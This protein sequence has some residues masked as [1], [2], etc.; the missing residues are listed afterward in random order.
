MIR[1]TPASF[2]AEASSYRPGLHQHT[3]DVR[4]WNYTGDRMVATP[5]NPGNAPRARLTSS[6]RRRMILE[7][8]RAEF[9]R[10]GFQGASTGRIASAA[11]CSEP[12]VYKHFSNKQSLF[13]EV[14]RD[15]ITAY[16][17][18]F[19]RIIIDHADPILQVQEFVAMQMHDPSFLELLNL[20]MLAMSIASDPEV[21]AMVLE[22]EMQTQHRIRRFV[23]H[24]V[25]TGQM[26][27]DTDPEYMAWG[28]LGI[29]LAGCY[30]NKFE[31]G[32]FTDMARHIAIFI[33]AS[34]PR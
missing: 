5:S 24:C 15:A 10:V 17:E 31:P 12:M 2:H 34:A 6:E 13:V 16:Q 26:H 1:I 19:E 20:R 18:P 32:S 8:A 11:G 4:R 25:D 9:A 21:R 33:E 29:M 23:E 28:W 7:A 14:L 27:P 30:R 3:V 22:L